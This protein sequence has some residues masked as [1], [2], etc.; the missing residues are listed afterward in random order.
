MKNE[1]VARDI[2]LKVSA[3]TRQSHGCV[4]ECQEQEHL[5][6]LII[7][8]LGSKD[9]E[10]ATLRTELAEAKK[11]LSISHPD[12]SCPERMD[13]IAQKIIADLRT[14]HAALEEAAEALKLASGMWLDFSDGHADRAL[15][16][17]QHQ[18]ALKLYSEAL[19]AHRVNGGGA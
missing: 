15:C 9:R 7:E 10:I 4:W 14:S 12:G 17:S 1:S 11:L 13:K 5:E 18:H 2:F 3:D 8:A 6:S 19:K 16:I